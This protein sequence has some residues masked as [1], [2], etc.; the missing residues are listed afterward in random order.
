MDVPFHVIVSSVVWL[1]SFQ[2]LIEKTIHP[3]WL[4]PQ[5][6]MIWYKKYDEMCGPPDHAVP[7]WTVI[8]FRRRTKKIVYSE[9]FQD[10]A[11]FDIPI[12]AIKCVALCGN[13][14]KGVLIDLKSSLVSTLLQVGIHVFFPSIPTAKGEPRVRLSCAVTCKPGIR[15]PGTPL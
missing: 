14:W 8:P 3:N 2:I 13:Y 1:R 11:G 9:I 7:F 5:E 6:W 12:F 10:L 4:T 15:R